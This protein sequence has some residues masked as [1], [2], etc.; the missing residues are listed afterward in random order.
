[1]SMFGLIGTP[2]G[3]NHFVLSPSQDTQRSQINRSGSNDNLTE[4]KLQ[5][6]LEL[7]TTKLA[8]RE[9][10]TIAIDSEG[11]ILQKEYEDLKV[12]YAMK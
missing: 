7:L 1:M 11:K 2:K 9:H 12:R 6:Q 3:N 5:H 4:T 8:D 10:K